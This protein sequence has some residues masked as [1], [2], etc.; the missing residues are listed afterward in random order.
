MLYLFSIREEQESPWHSVSVTPTVKRTL[1]ARKQWSITVRS[2]WTR[3]KPA[4]TPVDTART[5]PDASSMKG[6][7]R[8]KRLTVSRECKRVE[9]WGCFVSRECGNTRIER[10]GPF[11]A[12]PSCSRILSSGNLPSRNSHLVQG[13]CSSC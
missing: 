10:P 1:P 6:A 5:E 2:V 9:Q 4:Q 7:E 12:S 3:A 11:P 13:E 8:V